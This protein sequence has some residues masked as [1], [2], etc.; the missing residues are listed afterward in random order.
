MFYEHQ[1]IWIPSFWRIFVPKYLE[2]SWNLVY[3]QTPLILTNIFEYILDLV[4][5]RPSCGSNS[6]IKANVDLLL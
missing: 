3:I 1:I 6:E 4:L 5:F 2:N